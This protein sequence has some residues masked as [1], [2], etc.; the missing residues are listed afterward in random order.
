MKFRQV[1]ESERLQ[2]CIDCEP[3]A[4]KDAVSLSAAN[5]VLLRAAVRKALQS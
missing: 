4:P 1:G 5:A 2:V 3:R